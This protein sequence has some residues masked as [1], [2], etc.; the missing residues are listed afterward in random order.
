MLA[1]DCDAVGDVHF[2]ALQPER[3]CKLLDGGRATEIGRHDGELF[4]ATE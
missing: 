2:K 1:V 3:G 4:S